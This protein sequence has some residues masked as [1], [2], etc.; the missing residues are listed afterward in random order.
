MSSGPKTAFR[1]CDCDECMTLIAQD[2]PIYFGP[3]GEKLCPHCASKWG[4]VCPQ[5]SVQ[6]RAQ[7]PLCWECGQGERR[8]TK[9]A[10][11]F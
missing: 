10:Q 9:G 4:L 8:T 1:D 5:C 6:K 2:D 11:L 7:F 3:D